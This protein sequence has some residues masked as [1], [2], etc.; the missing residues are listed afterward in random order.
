M[1]R[2]VKVTPFGDYTLEIE[3]DNRHKII[4]DMKPRLEA[5]RFCALADIQKFKDVRI[6]NGDTLFWDSLCQITIS[7]IISL[8]ER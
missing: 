2:I 5:V 4:Y 3:L 6:E 8:V 7:E 1:S